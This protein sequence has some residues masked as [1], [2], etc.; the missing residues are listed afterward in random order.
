MR[1][2]RG[3]ELAEWGQGMSEKTNFEQ[4]MDEVFKSLDKLRLFY[5]HRDR[6]SDDALLNCLRFVYTS[7]NI[8]GLS[9]S[10]EIERRKMSPKVQEMLKG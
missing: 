9:L 2:G 6:F 8:A 7:I 1:R 4:D 10:Q 5:C 3:F